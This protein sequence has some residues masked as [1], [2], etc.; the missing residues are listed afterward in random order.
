MEGAC[1]D[2][3]AVRRTPRVLDRTKL[4]PLGRASQ[5]FHQKMPEGLKAIH[6]AD[7]S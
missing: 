3:S 2:R 4:P 1:W 7:K 5:P 6:L